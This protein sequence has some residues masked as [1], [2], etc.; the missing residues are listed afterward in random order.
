LAL[1]ITTIEAIKAQF[2]D[3]LEKHAGITDF[4]ESSIMGTI[5][6]V[7]SDILSRLYNEQLQIETRSSLSTAYGTY[8]DNIASNFGL[9][10]LEAKS[11]T[12][13]GAGYA[14]VFS[15]PTPTPIVV[16]YH[17]RVWSDA[18]YNIAYY[19]NTEVTVPIVDGNGVAGKAYVDV[20][21]SIP[22]EQFNVNTNTLTNHNVGS[23]FLTCTNV[24]PIQNGVS[25]ESDA[26]LRFRIR[27]ALMARRNTQMSLYAS[28]VEIPGVRDVIIQPMA[29]GAGTVDVIIVPIERYT[30]DELLSECQT[31]AENAVALGVNVR[32]IKPV[33]LA[34]DLTVAIT[35]NP[36][37]DK[38]L[39]KSNVSAA[40]RGYIDN[41]TIGSDTS[42]T[43]DF[44]PVADIILSSLITVI[45]SSS[46]DLIDASITDMRID[47]RKV[48]VGNHS[49]EPGEKF[50]LSSIK[51]I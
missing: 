19:T 47:G 7:A 46:S 45:R 36:T 43:E 11:A 15:N 33:E 48:V 26:N 41:L 25:V 22:G 32:C 4:S 10:R 49:V 34:V 21:A 14:M 39:V 13:V 28:L 24:R 44:V 51:V 9:T 6:N 20:A 30:T 38:A 50:Y 17:T 27:N 18:N 12:T 5:V 2:Q 8:L 23:Q 16:P 35:V 1:S 31:A 37:G 42:Q 29:R 3:A 40:I